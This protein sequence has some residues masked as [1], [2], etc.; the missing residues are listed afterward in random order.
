MRSKSR[1]SMPSGGSLRRHRK[2]G[3][4]DHNAD[5]Q[6]TAR[7]LNKQSEKDKKTKKA[8]KGKMYDSV[9]ELMKEEKKKRI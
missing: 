6:Q 8:H 9:R 4:P 2:F 5:M 3:H 1:L 7:L